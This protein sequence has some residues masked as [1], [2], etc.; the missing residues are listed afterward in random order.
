MEDSQKE[1][2]Q[3]KSS[4]NQKSKNFLKGKDYLTVDIN[5]DLRDK[6]KKFWSKSSASDQLGMFLNNNQKS[7]RALN[8]S[9]RAFGKSYFAVKAN[10][11]NY[12]P[13]DRAISEKAYYS[14]ENLPG[15][16]G[17]FSMT[18]LFCNGR[19]SSGAYRMHHFYYLLPSL[20]FE[21]EGTETDDL[22]VG[23]NVIPSSQGL[24]TDA[25]FCLNLLRHA[26]K[27][28]KMKYFKMGVFLGDH[29]PDNLWSAW[30]YMNCREFTY[31]PITLIPLSAY[32]SFIESVTDHHRLFML[33]LKPSL[34]TQLWRVNVSIVLFCTLFEN[35][36][37]LSFFHQ[38]TKI[39]YKYSFNLDCTPN[40][41]HQKNAVRQADGSEQHSN[42]KGS[43]TSSKGGIKPV[44]NA[45]QYSFKNALSKKSSSDSLD[46]GS[47]HSSSSHSDLRSQDTV[48]HH[49][50]S[51]KNN[52]EGISLKKP[53]LQ[54]SAPPLPLPTKT[55]FA[56]HDFCGAT[57]YCYSAVQT[58]LKEVAAGKHSQHISELL[59]DPDFVLVSVSPSMTRSESELPLEVKKYFGRISKV[60]RK[61]EYIFR[62]LSL[63]DTRIIDVLTGLRKS[64]IAS[65]GSLDKAKAVPERETRD[66]KNNTPTQASVHKKQ[67]ALTLSQ[68]GSV[69]NNHSDH[70]RNIQYTQPDLDHSAAF[71]DR[72]SKNPFG[73]LL[74]RGMVRIVPKGLELPSN[75]PL[76]KVSTDVLPPRFQKYR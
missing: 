47:F 1:F 3:L 68:H 71:E 6:I 40:N 51:E 50:K 49:P 46:S 59:S 5:E 8:E 70:K 55:R 22:L 34:I 10:P 12:H 21:N 45:G 7:S 44:L 9:M 65:S 19:D 39:A 63:A 76:T 35:N 2:L 32:D 62:E 15:F 23:S 13:I 11:D 25:V 37:L 56:P 33:K 41:N 17:K 24:S 26:Y 67:P 66:Y 52:A 16:D 18:Q 72:N 54:L 42:S 27:E 31:G 20:E 73:Q 74:K 29:M 53:K 43:S 57:N 30:R 4:I 64:S 69:Y 58:I 48:S 75:F 28:A 38:N 14:D 61:T 36:L 60:Q